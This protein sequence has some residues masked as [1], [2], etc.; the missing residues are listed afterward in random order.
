MAEASV[1]DNFAQVRGFRV[2]IDSHG[3]GSD[4]DTSWESMSSGALLVA[5]TNAPGH[6]TV[7]EITLRGPITADRKALCQWLN[8]VVTGQDRTRTVWITPIHLDGR[9]GETLVLMDCVPT[10]Y[11]PPR[12]SVHDAG[13]PCERPP[14]EEIRFTYG[15]W[16]VKP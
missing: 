11:V 10:A 9:L 12:L 13:D 2:E 1:G 5:R 15:D 4:V 3:G 6:K 7:D 14:M 16:T 8:D